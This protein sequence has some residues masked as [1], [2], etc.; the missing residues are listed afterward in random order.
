MINSICWCFGGETSPFRA[1]KNH[2]RV[3][4]TF[5][6]KF[7]KRLDIGIQ[8]NSYTKAYRTKWLFQVLFVRFRFGCGQRQALSFFDCV[9]SRWLSDGC[10]IASL[11]T[12]RAIAGQL[13]GSASTSSSWWRFGCIVYL[14]TE[15]K[16]PALVCHVFQNE[17]P[18]IQNQ[19]GEWVLLLVFEPTDFRFVADELRSVLFE[20]LAVI[21]VLLAFSLRSVC[22]GFAFLALVLSVLSLDFDGLS[23]LGRIDLLIRCICFFFE[24]S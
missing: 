7:G 22:D 9:C 14:N 13:N 16:S 1:R 18:T 4:R 11:A 17:M 2:E 10:W 3:F 12:H 15:K 24:Y 6:H 21:F 8:L 5:Q 20:S 23:V 19:S